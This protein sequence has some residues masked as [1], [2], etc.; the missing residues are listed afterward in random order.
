[1][2]QVKISEIEKVIYEDIPN[3]IPKTGEAVIE[4][5]SVGICGSDISVFKGINPV[6]KPPVVQGHEFGGIIKSINDPEKK[7]NFKAGDK[8][9]VFPLVNCHR[10]YYC[11]SNKEHLCENQKIFDGM[12]LDGAMKEEISVPLSNL[13]KLPDNFNILYSSL[14]EPISVG[15]H[16]TLKIKKS[17]TLVIGSGTVGLFAQQILALNKNTVISMDIDKYSLKKSEDF[18][19]NLVLNFDD[20]GN[21]LKISNFLAGGKLDY[22]IDCVGNSKTFEFSRSVLKKT[23]RIILIGVPKTILNINMIY[24][25]IN[26]LSIEGSYL[27][28]LEEFIES[29]ELMV[30]DKIIYKDI[31]SKYFPLSKAIEAYEYKINHPSEK[32]VLTN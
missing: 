31:I 26:E 18:G 14:V 13:I 11:N 16:A 19:S 4:V 8:V 6:L 30:T 32:V 21:N 20:R 24:L 27:Y 10:C 1:M 23:G 12:L 29:K 3:P 22:I 5:K 25:L 15:L 28:T 7:Y 9:C 2:L 17:N